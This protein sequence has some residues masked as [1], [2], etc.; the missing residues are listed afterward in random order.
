MI[1]N[2]K[3]AAAEKNKIKIK[4]YSLKKKE[5]PTPKKNILKYV[6]IFF[7]FLPHCLTLLCQ[8][9]FFRI[10][11]GHG[12]LTFKYCYYLLFWL[13]QHRCQTH[14]K[15]ILFQYLRK[16]SQ[17][18]RIQKHLIVWTCSLSLIILFLWKHF[19]HQQNQVI[20]FSSIAFSSI[21]ALE[22]SCWFYFF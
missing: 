21:D 13:L 17:N 8:Y 16:G 19:S 6:I 20:C 2:F 22:T 10:H 14:Q 18:K 9:Q 4:N 15:E 1:K 7:S 5:D 3:K 11:F 12:D